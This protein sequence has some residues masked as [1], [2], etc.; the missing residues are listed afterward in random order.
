MSF[1]PH[2]GR[3]KR[4][5]R[6]MFVSVPEMEICGFFSKISVVYRARKPIRETLLGRL[7]TVDAMNY[8]Q[9]LLDGEVIFQSDGDFVLRESDLMKGKYYRLVTVATRANNLIACLSADG[10]IAEGERVVVRLEDSEEE[11][12]VC[13][14]SRLRECEL[15][16]PRGAYARVLRR[17]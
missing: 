17:A 16:M 5:A 1:S 12:T 4:R 8:R 3:G 11:A 14:V 7:L 2:R 9:F 6:K 13:R 15:P 10:S